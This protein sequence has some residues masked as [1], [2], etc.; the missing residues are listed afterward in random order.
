[1]EGATRQRPG[2]GSLRVWGRRGYPYLVQAALAGFLLA[3]LMGAIVRVTGSGLGCPDWPLCH[4]RLIPPPDIHAWLEYLHRLSVAFATLFVVAMTVAA[5]GWAPSR[6]HLLMALLPGVLLVVQS[7]LGAWAVLTELHGGVALAHTAVAMAL[8]GSLAV[9]AARSAPWARRIGDTLA[10]EGRYA[11]ALPLLGGATFLLILT[12]AYVTRSGAALA[13]LPFPLCTNPPATPEMALLRE[14]SRLH[15][16]AAVLVGVMVGW[17]TVQG[18]RSPLWPLF[19]V[20]ALLAVLQMGFGVANKLLYLPLWARAAHVLGAALVFTWALFLVGVGW[21]GWGKPSPGAALR[22]LFLL[23]KPRILVLLLITTLAGMLAAGGGK[24]PW[25]KVAI[26]LMAGAL[27][28]GGANALNSF[29]DRRID[30]RMAR[31]RGRPLPAGVVE[32][33]EALGFGIGLGAIS[34][35][36]FA[37]W[38][39]PVSA[40]L[41]GLAFAYYVV[42]YTLLLKL[43]TP[44]N[45][46]LGGAAGAFPPLI[47]WTA[48]TGRV[49]PAALFLFL[50][51]FFWTPPHF[52]PLAILAKE[53]YRAAGVPMLPVVA[54]ERAAALQVLLY[55]LI[56][57]GV[58]LLPV[59]LRLFGVVY[60]GAAL[61]LGALMVALALHLY[62]SPHGKRAALLYRYS[63]LY[64]ALLFL[65]VVLDRSLT[66]VS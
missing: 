7:L 55:S 3:T 33:Y 17:V 16:T 40:V 31:T 11:L 13:C 54:G 25:E 61:L 63:S 18:M 26:T 32:P 2:W 53:D 51:V 46:V 37:L 56:L 14:V 1:M 30:A 8:L 15:W 24:V 34:L 44:Q 5:F 4:G 28:A 45:I 21:K 59:A 39:N 65:A 42:V 20:L 29:L 38:V 49:E 10:R 47:G 41:A 58:T 23:T 64:L 66:G 50:I 62:R 35:A 19:L 52:W 9:A 57:L 43:R 60:L 6:P 27:C 36:V 22:G 12:G 48:V